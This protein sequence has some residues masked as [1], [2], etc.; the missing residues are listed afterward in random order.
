MGNLIRVDTPNGIVGDSVEGEGY[1]YEYDHMDRLISIKNPLG[2]VQRSIRDSE[3]NIV[4]EVNP[5]FYD[6]GSKN[7]KGIEFIYDKDNRKIKTIFPDGGIERLFYDANGN[8][9]KHISPEYYNEETD[10]GLGYSYTYDSL[11]RLKEVINEDGRIEK[12]FEYDLNGNIIKETDIEGFSTLYKYDLGGNL[13]EKKTPAEYESKG[14]KEGKSNSSLEEK[15]K[16]F[17]GLKYNVVY[18]E[19]DNNGNKL[20]KKHGLD[21]ISA[22]DVCLRCNEIRFRYD[23]ENRLIE[24]SDKYGAK[25][26]YRYDCLNHKTF[27]SFKINDDTTKAVHYI[28]DKVGNLIERK[29]E[30]NGRFISKKDEG[31][32]V[33]SITKYEY[34]KN[35]NVTKIISPNGFERGRVYDEVDRVVEDHEIDETNGIFRSKVYEYDKAD[36]IIALREF[37]GE[38]AKAINKKYLEEYDYDIKFFDRYNKKKENEKLFKENNF[39]FDK[40]KSFKLRYV[41]VP[42]ICLFLIFPLCLMLVPLLAMVRINNTPKIIKKTYS[43]NEIKKIE[44]ES[45]KSLNKDSRFKNHDSISDFKNIKESFFGD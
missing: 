23:S 6:A 34:D 40:K 39:D 5:N 32:N 41:L 42:S 19:Y 26:K 27:E 21:L 15:S 25:A 43:I 7:G 20:L 45:F 44:S 29:E 31:R 12:T 10:D 2:S 8:V 36:N 35:G 30:I 22:D 1:H 3:G 33:W 11:N 13:I 16:Y 24:V 14:V 37:S 17:D 4:K 18:Y 28:Y 38:D 9:I